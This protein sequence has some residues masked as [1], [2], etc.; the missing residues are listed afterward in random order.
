M[1]TEPRRAFGRQL[2]SVIVI[3]V[4]FAASVLIGSL[5]HPGAGTRPT[6]ASTPD[7][8]S[9]DYQQFWASAWGAPTTLNVIHLIDYVPNATTVARYVDDA[10]GTTVG[11]G[12][13]AEVGHA[14]SQTGVQE[15]TRNVAGG[16]SGGVPATAQVRVAYTRTATVGTIR[17]ADST[18]YAVAG[19]V[20]S[21]TLEYRDDAGAIGR[22]ASG[23]PLSA[24]MFY[25]APML[26][27]DDLADLPA[28]TAALAAEASQSTVRDAHGADGAMIDIPG[29]SFCDLF[30]GFFERI[31]CGPGSPSNCAQCSRDCA[32]DIASDLGDFFDDLLKD[33][34]CECVGICDPEPGEEIQWPDLE[35]LKNILKGCGKEVLKKKLTYLIDSIIQTWV[36]LRRCDPPPTLTPVVVRYC[37]TPPPSLIDP[38]TPVPGPGVVDGPAHLRDFVGRGWPGETAAALRL[39][40]GRT[41][42]GTGGGVVGL[43][44]GPADAVPDGAASD[45]AVTGAGQQWPVSALRLTDGA[46]VAGAGPANYVEDDAIDIVAVASSPAFWVRPY[47]DR[48]RTAGL[49]DLVLRAS[50][51]WLT[52]PSGEVAAVYGIS[53]RL[54]SAAI[55]GGEIVTFFPAGMATDIDAARQAAQSAA[56]A[57]EAAALSARHAP[58]DA[59]APPA[60]GL[61][62]RLVPSLAH[63]SSLAQSNPPYDECV[64]NCRGD[65]L[66]DNLDCLLDLGFTIWDCKLLLSAPGAGWGAF[67]LC[68]AIKFFGPGG[69]G[70]ECVLDFWEVHLETYRTCIADCDRLRPTPFVTVVA[71][72]SPTPKAT[73]TLKATETPTTEPTPE[74]VVDYCVGLDDDTIEVCSSDIGVHSMCLPVCKVNNILAYCSSLACNCQR[75]VEVAC[76]GIR[77]ICTS[78]PNHFLCRSLARTCAHDPSL[79]ICQKLPWPIPPPTP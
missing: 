17:G 4:A 50:A 59:A 70:I 74:L 56:A 20:W 6:S 45:P 75:G 33:I 79:P 34:L 53:H 39:M 7:E 14:V 30:A 23:L 46:V 69:S 35:T 28:L 31:T 36:C 25:L 22:D 60:V 13:Y 16:G 71:A 8:L 47:R 49:D 54:V 37:A 2:R 10:S 65:L 29:I 76:A 24:T 48:L 58:D 61:F 1:N 11:E 18:D 38:P 44:S 12:T 15:V 26:V 19:E 9:G 52:S 43:G 21:V 63:A 72:C 5:G 77:S 41:G 66:A 64:L 27:S 40:A 57:L 32:C 55:P 62:G 78:N 42:E 67:A 51:G 73:A 68:V 3:A